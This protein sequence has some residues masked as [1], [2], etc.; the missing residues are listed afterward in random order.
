MKQSNLCHMGAPAQDRHDRCGLHVAIVMDGNGRWA[1]R[2]GLPRHRGHR[3]GAAAVRRTVAA[4][5]ALGIRVL[6]LYA[7]SSDNWRRPADE[8]GYLMRLFR[9]HL[10]SEAERCVR[11]GVR[12]SVIGR[13]DRL[14][15]GLLAAM[16]SIESRTRDGQV[17]HLQLAVDY[18]ARDAIL[19]AARLYGGACG[20]AARPAPRPAP[21]RE[22]FGR[23]L[24]RALHSEDL[25]PDVDLLIR[26]GGERRLSDF[27]LW[28]CA[29][30]ELVF[31]PCLW[32][33]F[34][35]SGLERAVEEFRGRERRFGG[36]PPGPPPAPRGPSPHPAATHEITQRR[37]QTHG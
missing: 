35:E 10:D 26:T 37:V 15:P 31:T 18:S 4:A 29:Y 16:E 1:Q 5:P 25:I 33:D 17:L 36:L 2:R 24:S 6:T 34:D 13:R 27:L 8:V 28:E 22:T 21:T 11:E 9:M 3:A 7:F 23:L 14:G 12:V 19:E 20:S 32:P 30:A